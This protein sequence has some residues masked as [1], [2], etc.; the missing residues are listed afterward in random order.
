ML[1]SGCHAYVLVAA[2]FLYK[3]VAMTDIISS[4]TA[5]IM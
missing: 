5:T 1:T 4:V 3:M 2:A